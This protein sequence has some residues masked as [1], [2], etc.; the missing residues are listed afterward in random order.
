MLTLAGLKTGESVRLVLSLL[1]RAWAM[2]IEWCIIR[3]QAKSQGKWKNLIQMIQ[4]SEKLMD[5]QSHFRLNLYTYIDPNF[6]TSLWLSLPL[7]N[8]QGYLSFKIPRGFDKSKM[9]QDRSSL[10]KGTS[11]TWNCFGVGQTTNQLLIHLSTSDHIIYIF[12][13]S[14]R[15]WNF[16]RK[17]GGTGKEHDF[18][19][20]F[21]VLCYTILFS[22]LKFH[23]GL[24]SILFLTHISYR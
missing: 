19:L 24:A 13:L 11:H 2:D 7:L 4:K 17:V 14:P 5:I 1:H 9:I 6:Q 16:I 8:V 21:T 10:F 23:W 15:R 3:N 18:S 22:V 12:F 20:R